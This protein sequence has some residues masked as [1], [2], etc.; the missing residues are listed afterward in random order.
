MHADNA[1]W[2]AVPTITRVFVM[3]T[4]VKMN[5]K[6]IDHGSQHMPEVANAAAPAAAAPAA[7][8]S[9]HSVAL[10][11]AAVPTSAPGE[12]QHAAAEQ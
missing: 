5:I 12:Q 8:Q 10:P 7:Q 6:T 1:E 3:F 2:R 11:P 9:A 4:W